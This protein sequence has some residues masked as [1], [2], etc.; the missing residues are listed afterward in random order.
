MPLGRLL[1]EVANQGG[2]SFSYPSDAIPEDSLVTLS[3]RETSIRELLD[4]VLLR[5]LDYVETE[6]YLILR[7][8][9]RAMNLTLQDIREQGTAYLVSGVVTI[10]GRGAGIPDASVYEKQLLMA[11]QLGSAKV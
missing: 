1:R 10:P 7:V 3:V 4:R 9:G 11:T 6:R 2:F 8:S 5:E